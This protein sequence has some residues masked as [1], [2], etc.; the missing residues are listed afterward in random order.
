VITVSL[1][2]HDKQA[3]AQI[4]E[5]LADT[6]PQFTARLSAFSR[7]AADEAMPERERIRGDR[8]HAIGS[9]LCRLRPGQPGARRLMYY[10]TAVAMAVAITLAVICAAL[11]SGHAGSGGACTERQGLVCVRQAAPSAPPA[12][13]GRK[14]G[15]PSLTP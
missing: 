1:N 9:A 3:L 15:A 13:S 11:V 8:Q 14:G 10:W 7:L 5:A 4:E 2:A 12:P 6:D